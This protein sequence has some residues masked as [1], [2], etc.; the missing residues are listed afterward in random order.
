KSFVNS[1]PE[2]KKLEVKGFVA[3]QNGGGIR[4]SIK[5]KAEGKTDGDITLGELLTVMPFG[6]NLTSLRMT[7]QEIVDALENGVSGI[8]T[9][10][11]RFPQVSG[12]RY[13]YDSKKQPEVLDANGKL[14][15]QGS[16]IVK[17]DIKNADGSYSPIDLNAY[18][19]VATNSFMANGGDF[20]RSMKAAKDAG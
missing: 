8:D 2:L 18:Y 7:G 10:Q 4:T 13:Y 19:F 9:K 20:Y 12:M 5:Q 15:T 11:G 6:N 1:N 14:V 17:V 16:R 3:I